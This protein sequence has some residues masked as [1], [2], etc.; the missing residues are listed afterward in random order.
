MARAASLEPTAGRG[1]D[2]FAVVAPVM[3]VML[4]GVVELDYLAYANPR[5]K[6]ACWRRHVPHAFPSR[7]TTRP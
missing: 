5:S 2:Q 4:F 3:I 7:K 6:A 1:H